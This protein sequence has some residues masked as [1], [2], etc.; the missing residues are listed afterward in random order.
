MSF[1]VRDGY[2]LAEPYPC[3]W[4]GATIDG[5]WVG[6]DGP[7]ALLVWRQGVA[8]PVGRDPIVG[9]DAT[10]Y[11]DSRLPPEFRISS[12]CPRGHGVV[13]ACQAPGGVWSSATEAAEQVR[14]LDTY[15]AALPW[16]SW[17]AL[18]PTWPHHGAVT[19]I[20]AT[21]D[22]DGTGIHFTG[23]NTESGLRVTAAVTDDMITFDND[24][25]WRIASA[26]DPLGV[27]VVD[28]DDRLV[29][30]AR[31]QKKSTVWRD[32]NDLARFGEITGA[33]R[34]RV[35]AMTAD[36][37]PDDPWLPIEGMESDPNVAEALSG[38][39][40]VPEPFD[41]KWAYALIEVAATSPRGSDHAATPSHVGVGVSA[42][43]PF[44]ATVLAT[45]LALYDSIHEATRRAQIT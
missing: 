33:R 15:A 12:H 32:E 28:S 38:F 42:T 4:C 3:A 41:R 18:A 17:E 21:I 6:F 35:G 44:A 5:G 40:F 16:E 23:T 13:L 29:M 2:Q 30:T 45:R 26:E 1:N 11:R 39:N 36:M 20:A 14:M 19:D 37:W 9:D 43:A 27:D 34:F 31:T 7:N 25:T 10:T 24:Q 8:E 22:S